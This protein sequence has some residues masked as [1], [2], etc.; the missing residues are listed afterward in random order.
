M[1]T[2]E[3]LWGSETTEH[4]RTRMRNGMRRMG[5]IYD[6]TDGR[7]MHSAAGNYVG[8]EFDDATIFDAEVKKT[9]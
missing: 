2:M 8:K 3:G 1:K 5:R 9:E 6:T 7:E 4:R